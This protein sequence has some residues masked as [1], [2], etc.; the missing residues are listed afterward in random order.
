MIS[1]KDNPK[2]DVCNSSYDSSNNNRSYLKRA[3][4][5]LRRQQPQNIIKNEDIAMARVISSSQPL[6]TLYHQNPNLPYDMTSMNGSAFASSRIIGGKD[7]NALY[8]E[9]IRLRSLLTE[10]GIN[11][12]GANVIASIRPPTPNQQ[13]L[14]YKY[15]VMGSYLAG[16]DEQEA[17]IEM[18]HNN[19]TLEGGEYTIVDEGGEQERRTS[20]SSSMKCVELDEVEDTIQKLYLCNICKTMVFVSYAEVKKHQ[21][22]CTAANQPS[23]SC[24]NEGETTVLGENNNGKEDQSYQGEICAMT[25]TTK[26]G[27]INR[28]SEEEGETFEVTETY[29]GDEVYANNKGEKDV[30]EKP[31][32]A[33]PQGEA[34]N[35]LSFLNSSFEQN[36]TSATA[37]TTITNE[38]S[39][40]PNSL[41]VNGNVDDMVLQESPSLWPQNTLTI[42]MAMPED[43]N[44]LIPIHC[45][46]RKH[47][48]HIF[49]AIKDDTI[50]RKIGKGK[51]VTVGQVGI[52]CPYCIS[53][54]ARNHVRGAVYFPSS[55]S[56]IYSAS[57]NLLQR[58]VPNCLS[59][60]K[61]IKD[62]YESL[63]SDE[64]RSG[65]SKQYWLSSASKLG[66][67]DSDF[68]IRYMPQNQV[69]AKPKEADQKLNLNSETANFDVDNSMVNFPKSNNHAQDGQIAVRNSEP[70]PILMAEDRHFTTEYGFYLLSLMR[71]CYFLESDRVGK[72]RDCPINFPGIACKYCNVDNTR[73]LGR[74]F[75]S[76]FKSFSDSSKTLNKMHEHFLKCRECPEEVKNTLIEMKKVHCIQKPK[77]KFGLMKSFYS[78]IWE[79][80]H[81]NSVFQTLG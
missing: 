18:L 23:E 36:S 62:T 21:E 44:C 54:F 60:P 24:P 19:Q 81:E 64:A 73:G 61:Y 42:P 78:R 45:F 43:E 30:H 28:V 53:T 67:V 34:N 80:L 7:Y 55:I 1:S 72:R 5:N 51:P 35:F 79:R 14:E 27:E 59:M 63:K 65:S 33:M 6:T 38:Q 74:L 3:I 49:L 71:R 46:V 52:C 17:G 10:R 2:N 32:V 26:E 40:V 22:T 31:A 76:S 69:D 70:E 25:S 29:N 13:H 58:H 16:N 56:Q 75:P 50:G 66:L 77:I 8:M 68:G 9:N 37:T 41:A 48:L 20:V 12:N 47:C 4:N 39:L 57:L 11:V 15:Q